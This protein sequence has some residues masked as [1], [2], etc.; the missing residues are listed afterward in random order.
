MHTILHIGAGEANE[1]PEM[2]Q[3]GAEHI[4][5]VEPNPELAE[6][7]RQQTEHHPQV[8]VIE[9]AITNNPAINQLQQFNLPEVCSL[10]PATG[11]KTLY[12]GLKVDAT[13]TVE[14]ISPDQLVAEHGPKPGEP[15]L[16]KIQLP[17]EEHNFLQ[18]LIDTDKLKQFCELRLNASPKPYFQGSVPAD[19]TLQ[20]LIDYG[21]EIIDE[22][23]QDPD[24]PSWQLTRDPLRDQL[25]TLQIENKELKID[26]QRLEVLLR[27]AQHEIVHTEKEKKKLKNNLRL[28]NDTISKLTMELSS[29]RNKIEAQQAKGTKTDAQEK[30]ISSVNST[31][32]NH[33][34]EKLSNAVKRL[35]NTLSLQNYL[36]TGELPLNHSDWSIKPDLALYLAEKIETENYDLVIEFGSGN[37]TIFFAKVL[38]EIYLKQQQSKQY[39]KLTNSKRTP[40]DVDISEGTTF[41]SNNR[42][43]GRIVSL[44]H[45]KYHYDHTIAILHQAGLEKMVNLIHT[46]L[47]DYRFNGEDYL[48][49]DSDKALANITNQIVGISPKI[50][51]LVDGPPGET[52]PCAK[53]PALPKLLNHL[54]KASFDLIVNDLNRSEEKKIAESWFDLLK[55]RAVIFNEKKLSL[56]KRSIC[57]S[58]GVSA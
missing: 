9:A 14:T 26:V 56:E 50:L 57:I 27:Q 31:L 18:T 48:F 35:E 32:M 19:K 45:N 34:D 24:W 17:G 38:R 44:E 51:V 21:Y 33:M 1:L 46:P 20:K 39:K 52:G 11:L 36:H 23:Q 16:L 49:Y 13:H 53:F 5:L 15:A 37:S 12:P 28:N 58:I 3:S 47:V 7:L 42:L 10:H 22:N 25:S 8:T 4:T 40:T 54:G 41:A 29:S 43:H 2:L 30:I 6:Q 55:R